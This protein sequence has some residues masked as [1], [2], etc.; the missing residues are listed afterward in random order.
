MNTRS[1]SA[2]KP[3]ATDRRSE[4]RWES[5]LQ[6]VRTIGG[7]L[8]LAFTIRTCLVEPFEIEGP[9][10]EPTLLNGDR[11]V[12]AKFP[13]G[14]YLPLRE[15][16]D[17]NWSGPNP[18]DV[19]VL[20]SPADGVDIIK[21]VIGVAGDLIE[22]RGDRV[23]RNGQALPASDV[24]ACTTGTGA[25]QPDCRVYESKI[26]ERDFRLSTAH[27][28]PDPV[29]TRVPERHVYVLGDHRDHSNDSRNPALGAIPL[30]RIKGRALLIYWSR[31]EDGIR[32]DRLF[33]QLH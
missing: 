20:R 24:A 8:F 16:A 18:G 28:T 27:I 5:T 33:K 10:M 22:V 7:A 31:G 9:S 25:H 26:G 13:F 14:L 6:N 23:Y 4:T 12:V 1:P 21:R 11:V 17:L 29:P 32:F 2:E 19:V 3:I 15:E 30:T